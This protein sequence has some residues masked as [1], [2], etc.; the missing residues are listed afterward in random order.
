[1]NVTQSERK[2]LFEKHIKTDSTSTL[3]ISNYKYVKYSANEFDI[4]CASSEYSR[5]FDN[6]K[7]IL[8]C[9]DTSQIL[10]ELQK[11]IYKGIFVLVSKGELFIGGSLFDTSLSWVDLDKELIISDSSSDIAMYM[12]FSIS[13]AA[14][15]LNLIHS[16]PYYPF[17]QI[18]LWENVNTIR[19]FHILKYK[20][21]KVIEMVQTWIPPSLEKEVESVY[22]SIKERLLKLLRQETINYSEISADL[23][24]G[25]DSATIIY[26][27]KA[28]QADVKLYHSNTD[29]EWNSDSKWAQL[30]SNDLNTK[31]IHLDSLSSTGRN[32]KLNLDY[33]NSILPDKPLFWADT[34]GYVEIIEKMTKNPKDAI[35]FTGLGGDELFTPMPSYA[36]S[37]VRQN[38]FRS[39]G[40]SLRYCF[41]NRIPMKNGF[42]NLLSNLSFK[43]TVRH[44]IDK[45]F[46]YTKKIHSNSTLN[47]CGPITVPR[48]LTKMYCDLSYEMLITELET[49]QNGLDLD[50]SRHQMIESILFQRH[51]VTQLNKIYGANGMS[52]K[53]PFL[54]VEIINYSLSIPVR[55]R[56][57]INLTKPILYKSTKGIVPKNIFTRGFKGDYSKE[58]YKSYKIAVKEYSQKIRQFK[59]VEWGIVDAD[60]LIS[61]LSMPTALHSRIESF[62]RLVSVERW[63]RIVLEKNK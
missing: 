53:A 52:W 20:S 4:Y 21:N 46:G 31:F 43:E 10:K 55:Y 33:S 14:V 39:I 63:I 38:K 60:I 41:L 28:L 35:H 37:L 61:E 36:W 5:I 19:P 25:V 6:E 26:I 24:G 27:L 1:M 59:L 11:N 8:N 30:I 23:S 13:K 40:L 2:V 51:I 16:L 7:I 12:N 54:D 17:Q 3:I 44:E 58:L 9:I 49:T 22:L 29:S 48:W 62:E 57:D 50:R 15:A 32:F 45:G 18:S 42:A 56:Q 47:W 34:E